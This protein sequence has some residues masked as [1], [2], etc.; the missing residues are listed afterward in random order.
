VAKLVSRRVPLFDAFHTLRSDQSPIVPKPSPVDIVASFHR[1]SL[2]QKIK[3]D[4]MMPD[5]VLLF[6]T[7]ILLLPMGYCFLAAP[8][9]LLVRLDIPPVTQLLRGLFN[10]YFLLVAAVGLGV[11]AAFAVLARRWF[12]RRMDADLNARDAGDPDAVRRLRRLHWG[13]MLCNAIELVT[14][15]ASIPYIVVAP[16]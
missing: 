3:G 13:G 6:A 10:G 5:P 2:G 12:L 15:V 14:I 11:I 8:A 1:K 16:A 4:R 7:V 9:F